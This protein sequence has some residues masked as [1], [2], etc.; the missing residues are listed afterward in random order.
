MLWKAVFSG[1]TGKSIYSGAKDNIILDVMVFPS[2]FG[3]KGNLRFAV[4]KFISL[5]V[6]A[7]YILQVM[8]AALSHVTH[9][10]Y[11]DVS[12]NFCLKATALHGLSVCEDRQ[13]I[14]GVLK[15]TE[16]VIVSKWATRLLIFCTY[17]L[18]RAQENKCSDKI[19]GLILIFIYV[20]FI[21]LPTCICTYSVVT[22]SIFMLH[23]WTIA[24]T[25]CV[26]HSGGTVQI[27]MQRQ[28]MSS[29]VSLQ[30]KCS[31][32]CFS[33]RSTRFL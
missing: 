19:I 15:W 18:E 7:F 1:Q 22:Y 24:K 21:I 33:T 2:T 14:M 20:L 25:V 23:S 10:R 31:H 3:S 12:L 27:R 13:E 9:F 8:K 29:H 16:E 26:L 6:R 28:V 11:P 17:L 5:S 32:F 30:N 4:M